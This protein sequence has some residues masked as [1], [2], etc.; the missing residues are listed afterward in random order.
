MASAILSTLL[1]FA[2]E[3]DREA[4]SMLE[5]VNDL[6]NSSIFLKTLKACLIVVMFTVNGTVNDYFLCLFFMTTS[7]SGLIYL[8]ISGYRWRRAEIN[9]DEL[10]KMSKQL[11]EHFADFIKIKKEN[12]HDIII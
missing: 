10:P 6:V 9:W 3:S 11:K 4:K 2:N 7:L 12:Y 5:N 1:I 8:K